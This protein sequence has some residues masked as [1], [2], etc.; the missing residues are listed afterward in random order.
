[1]AS[2]KHR[3]RI[4]SDAPVL[5]VVAA[6]TLDSFVTLQGSVWCRTRV[7]SA[8]RRQTR[9]RTVRPITASSRSTT[10]TGAIR[11]TV[12]TTARSR[13]KV[14]V[15]PAGTRGVIATLTL[16]VFLY[17]FSADLLNDDITDD[18]KCAKLIHKRHGFN[19]WYGWKN[20]CN[21]KKLPNVSSCF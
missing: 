14:S 4:V 5:V 10:S 20:H 19:A 15:C 11:A 3:C 8:H 13:A 6:L 2:R 18:I 21:G 7:R 1:M 9:T 12:Q 16:T 17:M